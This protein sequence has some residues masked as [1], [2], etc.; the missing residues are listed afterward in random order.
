MLVIVRFGLM[1]RVFMLVSAVF[2][3]VF[4]FV[5]LFVSGVNVLMRMLMQVFVI[6]SVLMLV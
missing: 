3:T 5:D 4:V 6:M 2:A 1:C